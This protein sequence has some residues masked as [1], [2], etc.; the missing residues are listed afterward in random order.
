[1][2]LTDQG[3]FSMT[4]QV[5]CSPIRFVLR[6]YL[7]MLRAMTIKARFFLIACIKLEGILGKCIACRLQVTSTEL[8]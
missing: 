5:A 7:L 2:A 4:I 8:G 6:P 1:M 3:I